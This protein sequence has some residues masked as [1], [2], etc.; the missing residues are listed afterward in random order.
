MERT[1]RER[2]EIPLPQESAE[3]RISS[4]GKEMSYTQPSFTI[5]NPYGIHIAQSI[6]NP[7][8]QQLLWIVIHLGMRVVAIS[9]HH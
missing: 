5:W 4:G 9:K 2:G 1:G 3:I 8:S 6:W 7:G